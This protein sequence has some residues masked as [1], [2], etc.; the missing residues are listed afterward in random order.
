LPRTLLLGSAGTSSRR[1]LI[2]DRIMVAKALGV[3][4][5]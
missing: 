4:V 2:R 3:I 5:N 1:S